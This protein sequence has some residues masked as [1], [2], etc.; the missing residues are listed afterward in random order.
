VSSGVVGRGGADVAEAVYASWRTVDHCAGIG[1]E[2]QYTEDGICA[3]PALVMRGRAEIARGYAARVEAGPRLSRHLVSN[4][5]VTAH[6]GGRSTASYVV[7]L[8]AA[9]GV[10][11]QELRHPSAICD[12]T[13]E[14]RLVD[15]Q[16]LIEHRVAQPIFVAVDNDS[17]LL[18]RRPAR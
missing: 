3:M 13:D 10:A 11:P 1:S 12:V 8:Y 9:D 14:F 2:A 6:D 15:G 18:G 16:W 7:T 4:L 17:V 5:I